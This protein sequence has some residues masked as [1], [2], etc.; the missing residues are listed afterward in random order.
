MCGIAGLTGSREPVRI[1]E[2]LAVIASRGPD[3]TKRYSDDGIHFGFARLAINDLSD[4][5][6]Q[7]MFSEDSQIVTMMNGEI[8][9][10]PEL[11]RTLESL[12]YRFKGSS[13]AEVIPHGYLVW[14]TELFSRLRG[15][16]AVAI[17]DRRS[18]TLI[19]ARDHFGIKPLYY[20]AISSGVVFSSSARAVTLHPE[21]GNS[22]NEVAMTEFVRYRYVS[23]GSP[24]YKRVSAVPPGC[25]VVCNGQRTTMHQ[26]WKRPLFGGSAVAPINDL[27]EKFDEL[28][29]KSVKNQLLS[30]VPLGVLL[31]GG[32]D[33]G[34]VLLAARTGS[35]EE[36]LAY[37]FDMGEDASEV[38][39]AKRIANRYGAVHKVVHSDQ[40]SFVDVY[41][42][43]VQCMDLPVGDAIIAPTFD[44]LQAVKADRKVVLTG[45]GADELMAGYAHVAP[46][47]L[48]GRV[49]S[50]G[51]SPSLLASMV[52]CVPWQIL[53][54][55]FP[56]QAELG[57]SGKAKIVD[58]IRSGKDPAVAVDYATSIL[59]DS[60]TA[61]GTNLPS[62]GPGQF[63]GDLSLT[64]L[65]EWG[66]ASWLPNQILNKMDQLSM[67]HGVEA[68]V[69]Y[70]DVDLYELT[71]VL[72]KALIVS[73]KGNKQV[74]R[75][76]LRRRGYPEWERPK[77][78]FF[79]PITEKHKSE[80]D[81]LAREWLSDSVVRKFGLFKPAL[82]A[83]SVARS[84]HGDFLA[85][86]QVATFAALHIW[87][88][89]DFLR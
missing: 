16:F 5:G 41:V 24:L 49:T 27:I 72:P 86:K 77:Q 50:W 22:L 17:F 53:D 56:Y 88:D 15:M 40:R 36:L 65:I 34:A 43:A 30:D 44:L 85:S 28:L 4:S 21:V 37:T 18:K 6:D 19:L 20:S 42:K 54:A 64:S 70:V 67:A 46:L 76:T 59:S 80:L 71:S 83:E 38:R 31:S 55:V 2:M 61:R 45:E 11:R 78:A 14:G 23:S 33:S 48:L 79:K 84:R 89:Q 25:F 75:E 58:I 7:P 32:I 81:S 66:F 57:R 68:R 9:N 73:R 62:L 26:Y 87:L 10:A 39:H 8:Y 74:L 47:Q 69:P 1:H 12:G 52:R 60:E 51:V 63:G 35:E 82:I 3:G 29:M 13:D